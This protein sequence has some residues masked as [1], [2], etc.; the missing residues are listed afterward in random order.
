MNNIHGARLNVD[1]LAAQGSGYSGDRSPD[2]LFAHDSWS[3]VINLQQ[4]PDGQMYMIDW[5]DR[6]QC[7]HGNVEGHDRSNGRVFKVSYGEPKKV[8]VDIKKLDDAGLV[9]ALLH[10]NDWHV[11]H[12][13]RVIQERGLADENARQALIKMAFQHPDSTR[14]LRGLW[15]LHAAGLLDEKLLARGLSNDQPLVRAW[16][17]QLACEGRQPSAMTL[18]KLQE[19]AQRDESPV[20]RLYLASACGRLELK[21]RWEVA[22]PLVKHTEDADDHNL[23]LMYWYAIEPLAERDPARAL[24]LALNG[25]IPLVASFMAR[26]VAATG[27]PESLALVVKQISARDDKQAHAAL[28]A[29]LGEALR[30]RRTVDMPPAWPQ[31]FAQIK[32]SGDA[33]TLA[34]AMALAVTFGDRAVIED[35]RTTVTDKKVPV[36]ER[37]S[38]LAA[39][40]KVR[41]PQLAPALQS[42]V[43][44]PALRSAALRG[45]ALYDDPKTPAAVVSVYA[46]LNSG[47]RRDAL[48]TLSSRV[49]YAQAL[50]AAVGKKEIAATDLSADLVRQLHNLKNAEL[51]K[52]ITEVWGTVRDTAEDKAEAITHY[53]KL[54]TNRSRKRPDTAL[55]RAVF[56]KTCQQCHTLFGTGGKVGPE[57]TGSNRANLDYVL[58]NVLDSSALVGKDYQTTVLTTTDGRVLTGIVRGEDNDAVTLVTANETI[59]VPK[60]EI[61][62]RTLSPKSMMPDD[63]WKPLSEHEVRSLVA[64]LASPEQVPALLTSEN[65]QNFFNGRDLAGWLGDDSL[66]SVENG[67]IVGRTEGLAKNE[68]LRSDLAAEDFRLSL[69]VKLVDNRGNSGIQF[70]S[71]ALPD[72]EMRG[73]QADIGAGWWG[74][75]YEENRRGLLVDK[76]GEQFV[77][78]GEWN[79]YEISAVGNR[80]RTWINGQLCADFQDT[81]GVPRGIFA[82]QLHSGGATEVRFKNLKL[83]P[84]TE[85]EASPAGR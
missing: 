80:I 41:D 50:L 30:G 83:E 15:A 18:E 12:A 38:A 6:N 63:L 61:D 69:D 51:D 29:G 58:S 7:H 60:G 1:Q 31:A 39:L 19:L 74:K 14:R 40:L 84:V 43:A 77:K 65:A 49:D 24:D 9:Q 70:R 57:L 23:P 56:A 3:Q 72:G 46:Q 21:E 28:I 47:E 5:Y 26:R 81:S 16:T 76:S 32:K 10:P 68:F 59:V 36:V 44:D 64:Y 17:I 42:L 20:V 27:S 11:R 54:I 37:Q 78:A 75:L 66:W 2:F 71:E 35:M 79:H 48:A 55:G 45:L 67:E 62:E 52:Q 33:A 8:D 4:G 73:Y 53:R 25:R 34:Q 13:R 85:G 82:L 22:A